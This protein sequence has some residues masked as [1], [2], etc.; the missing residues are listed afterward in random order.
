[1]NFLKT[2]LLALPV[3]LVLSGCGDWKKN[4]VPESKNATTGESFDLDTLRK[5]SKDVV[6]HG[7]DK[8]REI[9]NTVVVEKPKVVVKEESTVD[10]KF[11]VIT[12]DAQMTFNEGQESSFKVYARVLVP[13]VQIKLTAQ[14]LPEGA[15]L[16]ASE[17]E[18]DLYILKYNPALYTV[19]STANMKAVNVKFIAEVVSATSQNADKLKGLVREKETTLFV[20]KNQ[21]APAELKVEGLG[22][23]VMQGL[24]TVFTVTVKV[25]GI[26]GR[27]QQKP[28]LVVSYDG[29]SYTAGNDF[30]ELDGSRH[31]IADS[32]QKDPE[33]LGDSRWKFKLVFDTKKITV[34]P[35]LAKDGT[36]MVNANGV[37]V[38][39]SFKVYGPNGLS[40]PESLTQLKIRFA[41]EQAS[42]GAQ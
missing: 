25:P 9:T 22:A 37:R 4:P 23:E 16:E 30:L 6:T 36:F 5:H 12:P 32:K 18:K 21:E 7:P 20:F 42:Q 8:P 2:T 14:G 38:R 27:S 1:M 26:D 31:V 41:P 19:A 13:G 35:Q 3:T 40:T 15:T 33:Y 39:L 11:I 28:R 10:E 34:Q 29:V 24:E 17:K